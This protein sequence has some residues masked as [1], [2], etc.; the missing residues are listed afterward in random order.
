MKLIVKSPVWD[1][2][3]EIGITIARDKPA[4]ALRFFSATRRTLKLLASHPGLGRLRTF[5]Q[6]GIRSFPVLGFKNYIAF[7]LAR[8]T[9][10]QVLAVVHGGRDLSRIIEQRV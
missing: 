8:G 9:E 5:S 2:L 4:V 7:Y 1:D 10:L 3:R 6:S